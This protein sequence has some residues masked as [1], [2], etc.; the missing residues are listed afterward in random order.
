MFKIQ[1]HHVMISKFWN[2]SGIFQ[3]YSRTFTLLLDLRWMDAIVFESW[4]NEC[5]CSKSKNKM[6]IW[7][8]WNSSGIVLEY[9]RTIPEL[10]NHLFC[11]WFWTFAPISSTLKSFDTFEQPAHVSWI[12]CISLCLGHIM[13]GW[14]SIILQYIYIYI[15][16]MCIYDYVEQTN[17]I[18]T[19]Y[20]VCVMGS[21]IGP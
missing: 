20:R 17:N 15:I 6:I 21:S 2:S 19:I 3:N 16:H 4:R 1:K 14:L 9:S 12:H 11:F 18:C 10:F 5:K 7:K 13:H 8:F